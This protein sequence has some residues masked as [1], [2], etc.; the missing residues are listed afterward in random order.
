MASM[1]LPLVGVAG[2]GVASGAQA[3]GGSMAGMAGM[4]PAPAARAAASSGAAAPRHPG[5]V[6]GFLVT[7]GPELLVVSILLVTVSLALRRRAAA[8]P[9]L[10]AGGLLY[11]GMYAQGSDAL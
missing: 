6:L 4:G 10:V 7:I 3:S 9:A 11:W 8:L 5:G 1:L 2:A